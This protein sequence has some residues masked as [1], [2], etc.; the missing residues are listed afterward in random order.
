MYSIEITSEI[1]S[2]FD[3][4][5]LWDSLAGGVPF[6][7]VAWLGS[8][9]KH[10]AEGREAYLVVARDQ[11]GSVQGL[12]PLY[13][14]GS[15]T[16]GRT[17]QFM[18]D[19]NACTDD[20]SVLATDEHS[21]GVAEAMGRHLAAMASHQEFGW[22]VLDLDGIVEGNE[23]CSAL[24][25]GLRLGG[26]TLHSM[27]RMN[28]WFKKCE[29]TWDEGLKQSSKSS[30]R[31]IGQ[32]TKR[33]ETMPE[34]ECRIAEGADVE[35]ALARMIQMHQARWIAAG[36]KGTYAEPQFRDFI[37]AA[38]QAFQANGQLYLPTLHK[39]PDVIAA[40][41]HFI[42]QNGRSYCYSTGYDIAQSELEPG[43]LLN[44]RVLQH[45]YES[46]LFGVDLL[47]GDEP[48]KARMNAVP[49][50]LIRMRAVAPA[51]VPR[52]FHAAWRTQFELKQ[53]IRRQTGRKLIDVIELVDSHPAGSRQ[54]SQ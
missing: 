37:E 33:L 35:F 10:L 30:R 20:A 29:G 21:G 38:V 6:R 16:R 46:T 52:L 28:T 12:L 17:L 18:G 4:R 3:Q 22:D 48:Y 26:A 41:L 43:R 15:G 45:V 51:I 9:W 24:A 25:R 14:A 39:G 53:W 5:E 42:G 40:E 8:W 2:W 23:A 32:L 1:E 13:R 50:R 34:L 44:V 47:R 54:A 36:E 31:A 27:S 11:N 19:G 49:Q 7:Q